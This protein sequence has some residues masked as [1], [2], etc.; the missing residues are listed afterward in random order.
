MLRNPTYKS[1]A[2]TL[3]VIKAMEVL[4]EMVAKKT[5]GQ[6]RRW[7]VIIAMEVM[8]VLC[9]VALIHLSGRR[10][11]L[12]SSI[13][14]R[15][16]DPNTVRPVSA[17]EPPP[18]WTGKRTGRQHVT[19]D[20]VNGKYAEGQGGKDNAMRFLVSRALTDPATD[21]A[22]L[23]PKYGPL[24]RA[25]LA[26]KRFGPRSWN[27]WIIS[28]FLEFTSLLSFVS[29]RRRERT[30]GL[31]KDLTGLEKEELK[32]RMYL[33]LYYFLRNPLYEDWT[34]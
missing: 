19:I 18:V 29:A 30:I 32:K 23:V 6:K 3:A 10:T 17:T 1:I 31:R 16:Y 28:F 22:D 34:R 9:R 7:R 13:V 33:F 27:P 11:L 2:Y 4:G 15:D 12:H 5:G 8:K 21:A 25:A 20:V 26:S 24:R 14:D